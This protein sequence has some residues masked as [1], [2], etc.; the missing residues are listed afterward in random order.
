MILRSK[1]TKFKILAINLI[2]KVI[3]VLFFVAESNKLSNFVTN[4]LNNF[5]TYFLRV[6]KQN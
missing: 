2:N 6:W 5:G 3:T 4:K 1:D